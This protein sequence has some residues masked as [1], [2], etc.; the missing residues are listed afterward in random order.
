[1]YEDTRYQTL[2]RETMEGWREGVMRETM[3]GWR[4]GESER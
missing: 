2:M 1:V 3:E 4:E